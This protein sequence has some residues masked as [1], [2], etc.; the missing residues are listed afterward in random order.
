M[1]KAELSRES[2]L[3]AIKAG[4]K[5][6]TGVAH[7]HGYSGSVSSGTAAKIRKLVPEV[8]E[9]MAGTYVDPKLVETTVETPVA[10]RQRKPKT[11]KAPK[12][13]KDTSKYGGLYGAVYT[14]AVAAGE[15]VKREFVVSTAAELATA[16]DPAT[17]KA[18]DR[19]RSRIGDRDLVAQLQQAVTFALGVIV[20][21]NHRSN[22]GRSRNASED[23]G[24]MLVVP[25]SGLAG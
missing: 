25:M 9:R 15:V 23:R 14:K 20:S 8:A 1:S 16:T 10:K 5:S 13:P 7:A 11:P 12:T 22:M 4:A 3:E 17:V 2:I 6:L 21:P 18:V 19:V 24:K